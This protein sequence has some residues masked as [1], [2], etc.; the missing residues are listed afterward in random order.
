MH[1]IK[2]P[3]MLYNVLILLT[4]EDEDIPTMLTYEDIP[5]SF[6]HCNNLLC[7]KSSQNINGVL[8]LLN[9]CGLRTPTQTRRVT[10]VVHVRGFY[11]L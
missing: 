11:G 5:K 7:A 2:D 10:D 3:T 9:G 1:H 6:K 4:D 8:G